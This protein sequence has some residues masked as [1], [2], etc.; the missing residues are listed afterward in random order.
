MRARRRAANGFHRRR[1]F[2]RPFLILAA[3]AAA[4]SVRAETLPAVNYTLRFPDAVHH[5]VEV[6]ADLPANGRAEL[7]L[8]MPVWTPGSYLIR[9]YARNVDHVAAATADGRSLPI[10]KT[11]KNRWRV[12]TQGADRVHVTYRVYGWEIN[13][14][15][16]WIEGGFAML[17]GAPTYLTVVDDFQDRPYRVHVVRP[18][19]WAGVYTALP[20]GDAPD[21]FTAPDFDTLIDSPLLAGSPQ[22]DHCEVDG[23]PHYLVTIGGEGAWDNARVMRS[24]AQLLRTEAT[25]WG[26]LPYRQPYYIFNL[27]TDDRGGLEHRQGLVMMAD[28]WLSRTRGGINSWLSLVSHEYF[29]AWNGKRL[30]PVTLG[31][32]PYE[33]EAYTKSLWVVEGITSYYQHIMMLRA[34]FYTRA[35]YLGSLSGGIAGI[36]RVPG[37]L[38]QS[39]SDSSFDAWIKAYRPDENSV[40]TR[41]SYYSAGAI[42]GALLDAEI[43]RATGGAK[44]LDDVMRLAFNRYSGASGYTEAQFV[45]LASEVAGTDLAPWFKRVVDEP[46]RFDYQPLLDW[47]G[48]RF[49][50]PKPPDNKLLPNGL[51]PSDPPSGW[52]GADTRNSGGRVVVTGVREGTPAYAAGLYVDD[53]IVA[54]N[55]FRVEGSP[56]ALVR[57]HHVGDRIELTV[58]RHDHLLSLP[59]VL[60]AE[61]KPTWKLEVRPD[62]TP[63]QQA[64]L[65]AWIG[66]DNA[67]P[68]PADPKDDPAAEPAATPEP[69]PAGA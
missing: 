16:N 40:N 47:Y 8:F 5:Y 31:P 27:L 20:P 12:T 32:F 29:H 49:E 35:D 38:V 25:F 14:R 34:G 28:R 42:A 23:V 21:T 46:G 45:A 55:G 63:A 39:L 2:L 58:T 52:L 15:T 22:V 10:E 68:A 7:D 53:E 26:G 19:G 6:E 11:I 51:E 3:L 17:N 36:E 57:I 43:R 48:L 67:K 65:E 50:T 41:T 64:H 9:E 59:V 54:V 33:H 66:P 61:P 13:V 4:V 37:R 18:D 62:A 44:S 1:M 24:L 69:A 56:D 60:G 30:R